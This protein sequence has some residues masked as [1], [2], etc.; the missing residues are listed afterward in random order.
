[1]PRET[2]KNAS[3]TTSAS[4]G[5]AKSI[6]AAAKKPPAKTAPIRMRG[7]KKPEHKKRNRFREALSWVVVIACAIGIAL[8]VRA[9]V[10]EPFEI[11][12]ESMMQTLKVGDRLIGEKISYLV[13]NPS[14]GDIATFVDPENPSTILIKRVIGTPGD[15]IDI[16]GDGNLYLNGEKQDEA[17][18]SNLPTNPLTQSSRLLKQPITYPYTLKDNEYWM[19]GDNRTN[20]LDS[21]YFGPIYRDAFTSKSWFIYYPFADM[22]LL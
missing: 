14:R 4:T 6:S 15:T 17:Y 12:S 22:R 8:F 19:M 7:R 10:A 21:R 3:T 1:M 5:A 13:D 20:S 11:P 18:T 2:K 16:P 9:F